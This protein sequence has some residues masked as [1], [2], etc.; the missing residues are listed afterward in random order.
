MAAADLRAEAAAQLSEARETL[1]NVVREDPGRWWP[2]DELRK[3]A[4]NGFPSTIVNL[5]LNDL[6]DRE[7]LR[8]NSQLLIQFAQ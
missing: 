3:A 8:L 6:V 2:A 5:A 7:Q 1:L 4:Q